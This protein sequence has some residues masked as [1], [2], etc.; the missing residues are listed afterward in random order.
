MT[1]R[2]CVRISI[3]LLVAVAVLA[4]APTVSFAANSGPV[5]PPSSRPFGKTYS[6]WSVLWWQWFLPLTIEQFNACTIG[7]GPSN[8][9]FLYGGTVN[10]S[11]LVCPLETIPPGTFLF[12]PV[13]NVECSNLEGPQFFGATPAER[14][15][16]AF[17]YFTHLAAGTVT[18][19]GK[20]LPYYPIK[21]PDFAFTVGS[22]N[23]NVFGINCQS[24]SCTGQSTGYGYYVMLAPLPP[25]THT[26]QI[27][28]SDY[29]VD[30][31]W[32]L[33]VQ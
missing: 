23:D 1:N 5:L 24:E 22:G 2:V 27:K 29:G 32:T 3:C 12:F 8:V 10:G 11:P 9:K 7:Q 17:N 26:I 20:S 19:D 28:A 31:T 25:G 33:T 6:E 15:N 16:C 4:L 30:T 18:L 14:D 21:S 13:G